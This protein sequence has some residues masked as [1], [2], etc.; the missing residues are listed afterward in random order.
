MGITLDAGVTAKVNVAGSRPRSYDELPE[1]CQH[2]DRV[3]PV[4]RWATLGGGAA[5]GVAGLLAMR[6]K[7]P[8]H[9]AAG[10]LFGG[11]AGAFAGFLAGAGYSEYYQRKVGKWH[12]GDSTLNPPICN[13]AYRRDIGL[14]F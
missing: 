13:P 4:F 9:M 8:A 2:A 7:G 14:D 12:A 6:G 3:K 1:I 10:L 11:A 5:G